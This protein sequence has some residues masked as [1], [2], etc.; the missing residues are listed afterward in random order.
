MKI[1]SVGLLLMAS[2]A[3]VLVGCSD[4][5]APLVPS[6]NVADNHTT[7]LMKSPGSG[8]TI[9][10][11]ETGLALDF[12]DPDAG[13]VLVLGVNDLA[14]LCNGQGGW[15]DVVEFKR[16]FLPDADP[17]LKRMLLQMKDEDMGAIVWA[18]SGFV[19][20]CL[21]E[22]IAV[23]TVHFVRTDNDFYANSQDNNNSNAYGIT[24]NGTLVGPDGQV[25]KLNFVFRGVWDGEDNASRKEVLKIQLTPTGRK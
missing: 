4:N 11:G 5:S 22:P 19:S 9:L 3:I 8:A 15:L 13:L 20:P 21:S 7:A 24:A 18:S 25:Y 23:G 1:S 17:T 12:Y 16:I 14:A 6:T 10:R 2:L